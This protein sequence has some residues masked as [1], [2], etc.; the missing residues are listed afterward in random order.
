VTNDRKPVF[1]I[2]ELDLMVELPDIGGWILVQVVHIF[3]P[4]HVCVVF[5]YGIQT[6]SELLECGAQNADGKLLDCW[7]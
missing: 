6:Y 7:T 4:S 2:N 5:P 1:C 3:S